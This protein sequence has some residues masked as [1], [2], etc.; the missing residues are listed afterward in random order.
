MSLHNEPAADSALLRFFYCGRG[1]TILLEARNGGCGI[2]DCNLTASS[3]AD[4]RIRKHLEERG[5]G[6]LEFVCLTHPDQDHYFGMKELL[7]ECFCAHDRKGV[8]PLFKQFWDSG[9]DFRALQAIADRRPGEKN[10]VAAKRFRDL[11]AFLAPLIALDAVKRVALGELTIPAERFG[12]FSIVALGPRRNRVDHFM[13]QKYREVL[14]SS[15]EQLQ[16]PC[17]ESNNLSAVLVMMHREQPLNILLGGDATVDVWKEALQ[18]WE[19]LRRLPGFE[20]RTRHFSGVKVSHHG[21]R[22]SLHPEL[23][24]D[25]CHAEDTVAVLSVGPGDPHHP[26]QEVLQMLTDQGIRTYATCWRTKDENR[27]EQE[28]YGCLPLPGEPVRA[29]GAGSAGMTGPVVAGSSPDHFPR[30]TGHTCADIEITVYADGR[31]EA[32][33]PESLLQL[34]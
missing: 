27:A 7:A 6:I 20:S 25:Y 14:Q 26:H 5:I 24:Q 21:A 16:G 18:A 31:L 11:N 9:A 29:G 2:I 15:E 13:A 33:P 22:G 30:L 32:N 17:E 10:R 28:T 12:D 34:G 8:V 1:D 23:Y 3:R 4:R 19:R